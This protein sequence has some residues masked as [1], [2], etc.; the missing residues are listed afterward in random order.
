MHI[1]DMHILTNKIIIKTNKTG[2]VIIQQLIVKTL[3]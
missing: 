3:Q 2:N 1:R